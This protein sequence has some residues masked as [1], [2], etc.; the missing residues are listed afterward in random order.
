MLFNY[1][2]VVLV[3]VLQAYRICVHIYKRMLDYYVEMKSEK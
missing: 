2:S 1:L 3:K